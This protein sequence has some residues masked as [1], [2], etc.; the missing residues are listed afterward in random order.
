MKSSRTDVF[1]RAFNLLSRACWY[2]WLIYTNFLGSKFFLNELCKQRWMNTGGARLADWGKVQSSLSMAFLRL[3]LDCVWSADP[4]S[5]GMWRNW[6]GPMEDY[7]TGQDMEHTTH[8][9]WQAELG[10]FNLTK[11]SLECLNRCL[12]VLERQLQ[13]Y[14][15]ITFLG[16]GRRY[17]MEQWLQLQ[18]REFRLDMRK[19]VFIRD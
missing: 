18:L 14:W 10:L 5:R 1:G 4:S 15:N 19:D 7:R 3:H 13:G 17:N 8:R 12:Q 11:R 6:R 16:R 9:E 2:S